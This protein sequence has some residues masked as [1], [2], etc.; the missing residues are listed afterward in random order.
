MMLA[1]GSWVLHRQISYTPTQEL[2]EGNKNH[3]NKGKLIKHTKC[4]ILH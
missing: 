1:I 4:F 2:K 3:G